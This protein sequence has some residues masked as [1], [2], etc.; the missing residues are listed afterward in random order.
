MTSKELYK[1]FVSLCKKWP[2]DETKYGRDYGEYF[3]KQLQAEFPHGELSHVT[4]VHELDQSISALERI[5]NNNYFNENILKKSSASGL[6]IAA[7]R[8]AVSTDG[9]RM[10]QEQEENTLI[11]SLKQALSIKFIR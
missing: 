5:A 1:R 9:L 3:R 8:F 4:K 6:D 11:A 10:I 7:C 2:K